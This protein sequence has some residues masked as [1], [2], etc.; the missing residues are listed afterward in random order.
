MLSFCFLILGSVLFVLSILFA[1][2]NL[3]TI[4]GPLLIAGFASIALS[5]QF[6]SNNKSFAFTAWVLA[7]VAAGM[8]YPAWFQEWGSFN[9]K[10]LIIPLIQIIMFGMG[11]TL[12]AAD[13][14]RVIKMPR[15]IV[16]GML[17]QFTVMPFAG[18]L[19]AMG[20][21]FEASIA[22]GI[23]LVGSCPGGV[24]SNVMTFI[25]RGNVALSVSMT[26]CSTLASPIMTPLMM[27]FLAGR[28]IAIPFLDM[29]ITIIQIIIIPIVAGLI[30]NKILRSFNLFGAWIEKVLSILAM[31]AI[32]FILS[33]I[34]AQSRDD[35]LQIGIVLFCASIFHNFIGYTLGYGGARLLKLDESSCRTVAIEVGLQNGGM[36]TGLAINVLNN[37]QTALAPAIFG[38]WMNVSGSML[39]SWWRSRPVSVPTNDTTAITASPE[40]SET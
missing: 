21:G 37:M 35:L 15:A 39:A 29:M 40:P 2:L 6:S 14:T 32:C 28:Y 33:I 12:S 19:I 26:A 7:F 16:I 36:A 18:L 24:A 10:S 1:F 5:L 23:V 17:L 13:F 20:F 4:F 25:A 27:K 31:F 11:T 22:A 38:A 8:V 9:L 3:I 30:A 34:V